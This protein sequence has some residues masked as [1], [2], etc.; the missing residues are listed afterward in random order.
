MTETA[1]SN[2]EQHGLSPLSA[3]L[4]PLGDAI[5]EATQGHDDV[6]LAGSFSRRTQLD[7]ST[8]ISLVFKEQGR[9]G[10]GPD[11]I[12]QKETIEEI[13]GAPTLRS[14]VLR[15]PKDFPM[16][17]KEQQLSVISPTAKKDK[18]REISG[19]DLGNYKKDLEA[20]LEIINQAK[21]V[22]RGLDG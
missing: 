22:L 2:P 7:D 14:Y 9:A 3:E 19:S 13:D 8:K 11:I 16:E 5:A 1:Q 10:I 17:A 6:H 12:I 18:R 4:G 15:W 21:E 20:A